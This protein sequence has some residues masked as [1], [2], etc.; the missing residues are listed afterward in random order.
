MTLIK[1][2]EPYPEE[3]NGDSQVQ[4]HPVETTKDKHKLNIVA[5]LEFRTS[6]KEVYK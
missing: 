5:S 4:K 2:I 6:I 1:K 3:C